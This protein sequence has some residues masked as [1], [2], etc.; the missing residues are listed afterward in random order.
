MSVDRLYYAWVRSARGS[1]RRGDW[2]G[3]LRAYHQATHSRPLSQFAAE[4]M[5]R[6]CEHVSDEALKRFHSDVLRDRD[7]C[8]EARVVARRQLLA[9]AARPYVKPPGRGASGTDRSL[10][11]P[12]AL[13][14][15]PAASAARF[16]ES[17]K[18][19]HALAVCVTACLQQPDP[20]RSLREYTVAVAAL[21]DLSQHE[22]AIA[23]LEE[24]LPCF[25]NA[26]YL[27][28]AALRAYYEMY[29]DFGDDSPRRS[30]GDSVMQHTR[31]RRVA[32]SDGR[33]KRLERVMRAASSLG[34]GLDWKAES[35]HQSR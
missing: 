1:E 19:R 23:L 18:P 35:S 9:I 31:Q 15:Q 32:V 20:R 5:E 24:L 16:R 10:D 11:V 22:Y 13:L 33:V 6:C 12:A 17:N 2:A 30:A 27:R 21:T 4:A 8:E 26:S 3:A 25:P 29:A 28:G 14:Q 34:K 7:A